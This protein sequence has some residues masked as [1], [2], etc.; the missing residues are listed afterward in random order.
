VVNTGFKTP[1]R[2]LPSV[3]P[4]PYKPET[5]TIQT[6]AKIQA[7]GFEV[8]AAGGEVNLQGSGTALDGFKLEVPAGAYPQTVNFKIAFAP[9]ISHTFSSRLKAASPLFSLN[10]GEL[11]AGQALKIRLPATIPPGHVAMA[12]FYDAARQRLEALPLLAQDATSVT[13]ATR[14]FSDLVV[15]SASKTELR[16]EIDTGFRPGFDDWQ[17]VNWGSAIEP[18]GHCAGQSISAMWYFVNKP[19]GATT[20]LWGKYDNFGDQ[21]PTPGYWEDDNRAYRLASVV[22]RDIDWESKLRYVFRDLVGKNEFDGV[23]RDAFILS[24]LATGEPQYLG[25][26]SEKGGHAVV[27]YK[28]SPEG[29]W[30]ADPN[31]PSD[32]TALVKW[33]GT[34]FENYRSGLNAAEIA[35]GRYIEFDGVFYAAQSALVPD[36]TVAARWQQLK[37]GTVGDNLFPKYKLTYFD[38]QGTAREALRNAAITTG[39]NALPVDWDMDRGNWTG[40]RIQASV[41]GQVLKN[42]EDYTLLDGHL[43]I[44]L[45]AGLNKVGI[46][47]FTITT[48]AG[49]NKSYNYVDH[50]YL[51]VT[52]GG[53]KIEPAS[54]DGTVGTNYTFTAT[55][56]AGVSVAEYAWDFGDN[57]TLRSPTNRVSHTFTR[58]GNFSVRV[59][60]YDKTGKIIGEALAPARITD[61]AAPTPTTA[62]NLTSLLQSMK[63]AQVKLEYSATTQYIVAGQAPT[64]AKRAFVINFPVTSADTQ[65]FLIG[66]PDA[67][68]AVTWNGN[69]FS[70]SQG[71]PASAKGVT[72]LNGAFPYADSL[73]LKAE[74]N[75]TRLPVTAN[76]YANTSSLFEVANLRIQ[77]T[78][79]K[80]S[81][82]TADQKEVRFEFTGSQV[83]PYLRNMSNGSETLQMNT[84]RNQYELVNS[85]VQGEVD[86][87]TLKLTIVFKR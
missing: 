8:G 70:G 58:S 35:A 51:N 17:F 38:D 13:A 54:L 78:N 81:P 62:I 10:N 50:L 22:Q 71:D 60:L 37:A 7:G 21:P 59:S 27:A 46:T 63:T 16:L 85:A 80:T 25:L 18:G 53:T 3:T 14:H 64:S 40:A 15:L 20:R 87:N 48:S 24:M 4:P 82:I 26:L 47:F 83:Q 86:W 76:S 65:L 2:I 42:N 77:G 84:S 28:I 57:S 23:T 68:Q 43:A 55:P 19:D 29:I 74:F 75:R 34:S 79:L 5:G 9:V 30:I 49:G 66:T 1:A 44:P 11:A 33:N 39:R 69:A 56:A 52:S 12:F 32:S 36:A 72:R 45:N 73:N 67:A 61:K 6:G 31:R 41:N